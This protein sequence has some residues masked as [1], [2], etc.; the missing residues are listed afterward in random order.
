[1][2]FVAPDDVDAMTAY[3]SE[4]L[5]KKGT[6]SKPCPFVFVDKKKSTRG[7]VLSAS[8]I[9]STRYVV[10]SLADRVDEQQKS[11]DL[12]N[13]QQMSGMIYNNPE[14]TFATDQ[15]GNVIAW[16]R[17]IEELTGGLGADILGKGEHEYSVPFF[18][19]RRPMIIDLIFASDSEIED[20]GYTG[21]QWTGNT[22]AAE[23]TVTLSDGQLKVIREIASP[24]FNESGRPAGAIESITDVT[25]LRQR[26]TDLQD[27]ETRYKT[28]LENT[29]S[30]LAIIEEDETLSYLNPEFEKIIGYVREE[31]VGRKKLADFIAPKDLQ[32]LSEYE[33]RCRMDRSPEMT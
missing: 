9:P 27:S 17:A 13:N 23:I 10:L 6:I 5:Q 14:A 11:Q 8:F 30:A 22:L 28:I 15:Q 29:G 33:R 25:G 1:M 20:Q 18:Q 24:I 2:E 4:S 32:R 26:E 7:M 12:C 16:N 31:V 21:I 3:L 19:D